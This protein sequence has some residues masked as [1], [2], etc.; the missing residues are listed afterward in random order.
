VTSLRGRHP[1]RVPERKPHLRQHQRADHLRRKGGRARLQRRPVPREAVR[2]L[3][4]PVPGQGLLTQP[5]RVRRVPVRELPARRDQEITDPRVDGVP[6]L[7]TA[8]AAGARAFTR[9]RRAQAWPPS[10]VLG[11]FRAR[12]AF[13]ASR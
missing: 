13:S 12:S 6:G 5:E 10:T 9:L 2:D 8:A 4:R 7:I 3:R 1:R 11:C